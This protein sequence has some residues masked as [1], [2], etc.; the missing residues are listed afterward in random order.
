[1]RILL[2]DEDAHFHQYLQHLIEGLDVDIDHS[3]CLLSATN[4]LRTH[5]YDLV[6]LEPHM[7]GVIELEIISEIKMLMPSIILVV[8]HHPSI[9]MAIVAIKLGA[10]N[11]LAKTNELDLCL[12]PYLYKQVTQSHNIPKLDGAIEKLRWNHIQ[13]VLKHMR[14]NVTT[15]AKVLGISRRTLHRW[16]TRHIINGN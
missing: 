10:E 5:H 3:V 2:I 6:I 12:G 16:I 1:M 13:K 11:Y 7:N 8:T 14:G 4:K 9:S 15:A